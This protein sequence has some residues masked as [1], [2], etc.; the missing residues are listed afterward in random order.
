MVVFPTILSE[1]D[2]SS[3]LNVAFFS[4]SKEES[5][6]L[7]RFGKLSSVMKST[8][9]VVKEKMINYIKNEQTPSE[10]FVGNI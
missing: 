8:S 9:A 10:R 6:L 3:F 4:F 5:S 1:I 2:C 7:N